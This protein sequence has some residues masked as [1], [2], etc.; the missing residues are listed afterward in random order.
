[1]R[2][3][4]KVVNETFSKF[5][6][7][8]GRGNDS[9]V[10]SYEVKDA[11][12]VLI[13]LGS[14]AGTLRRTVD[15]LRKK[16]QK[17]GLL[18]LKCFRPFPTEALRKELRN[19]KNILVFDRMS[20]GG[21]QYGALF[22]EISAIFGRAENSPVLKN[23]IYGLGGRETNFEDFAEVIER[24]EKLPEIPEWINLK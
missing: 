8:F 18:R 17:V 16:G 9:L 19:A 22:L 24:F 7:K 1:M 23:A 20:P 5:Q 3:A 13:V 2:N 11:E 10:D 4:E 14:T 21:A 12:T 6:K 15:V